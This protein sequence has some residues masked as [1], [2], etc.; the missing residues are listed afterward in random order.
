MVT[1]R[2][3]IR[4]V[5]AGINMFVARPVLEG[6]EKGSGVCAATNATIARAMVALLYS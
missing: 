2:G 5:W 1:Y 6:K 3:N 4:G